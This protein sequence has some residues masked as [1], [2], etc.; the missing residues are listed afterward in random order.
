M[1]GM[2]RLFVFGLAFALVFKALIPAGWMPSSDQ[3]F[4]IMLCAGADSSTVWLDKQGQLHKTDPAK[5]HPAKKHPLSDKEHEGGC[6]F[7]GLAQLAKLD[8]SNISFLP[9]ISADRLYLSQPAAEIGLGLAAP[10]P[11]ST[12]PPTL[13]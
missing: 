3:A 5:K 1:A 7:S 2:N 9:K 13:V 8:R 6:A 11:P 4:A 12:G 10:P